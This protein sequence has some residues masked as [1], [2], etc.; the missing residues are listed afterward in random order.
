MHF[1]TLSSQGSIEG[2]RYH[3]SI[4]ATV[5]FL[6][7]QKH[8]RKKFAASEKKSV[9]NAQDDK[10]HS[11]NFGQKRQHISNVYKFGTGG[12]KGSVCL[13]ARDLIHTAYS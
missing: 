6:I 4:K 13:R 8:N 3:R 9:C 10:S 11:K 7:K 5:R 12:Q 1:K 2:I